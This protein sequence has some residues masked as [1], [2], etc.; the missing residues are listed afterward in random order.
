MI[1]LSQD[2]NTSAKNWRIASSVCALV[3]LFAMDVLPGILLDE[4][5]REVGGVEVYG[6]KGANDVGVWMEV[7]AVLGG[8][9]R[10]SRR[11]RMEFGVNRAE[12]CDEANWSMR[13]RYLRF[14]Q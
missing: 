13:F 7:G 5:A 3:G 10:C 14:F 8:W 9:G 4:D 6:A 1:A 11:K 2:S 12:M